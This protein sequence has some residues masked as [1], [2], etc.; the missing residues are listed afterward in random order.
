VYG[1]FWIT[2]GPPV[3]GEVAPDS[4]AAFARGLRGI[5][6]DRGRIGLEL[7]LLPV[8]LH[9][10]IVDALPGLEIVD[11]SHIFTELRK[12]K[13]SGE[14]ERIRAATHAIEAAIEEAFAS[15]RVGVTEREIDRWIREG[16]IRR[17]AEPVSLSLG[18]N[19]RGAL[20]WSF[21]TDRPVA[22]GDVVRA[23]ITASYGG[24]CSDLARSCVVGEPTD[25]Q[26]AYYNAAYDA[27][28]TGIATVRGGGQTGD[29][30]EA[31]MGV[32]RGHGFPD[33]KR[34]HVGH[35]LGLQ[36]HE[37]PYLS[38]SGGEIPV[39]AVVAVECPFYV[40]GLGGFSPEDV[41]VVGQAGLERLTHAPPELPVVG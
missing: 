40:Y 12:R 23:D 15:I 25:E 27:V 34:P 32:A 9:R 8:A 2:G 24:Y 41:L 37:A 16:L 13:T 7:D 6:A 18:T 11:S 26:A 22:G 1:N 10:R 28:Q 5:G 33:F 3:D 4:V 14:V 39:D 30:F 38:P 20:V 35:G 31:A 36:V 19:G 17:G 21:V 29:V